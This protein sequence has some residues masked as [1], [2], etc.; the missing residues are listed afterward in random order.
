MVENVNV[1]FDLGF[2]DI[3][4]IYFDF[5]FLSITVSAGVLLVVF[6]CPQG[7]LDII[8]GSPLAACNKSVLSPSLSISQTIS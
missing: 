4:K 3:I 2:G 5:N 6:T 1:N 7:P 8:S